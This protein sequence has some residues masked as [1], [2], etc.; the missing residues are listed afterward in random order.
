VNVDEAALQDGDDLEEQHGVVLRSAG[1]PDAAEV[2]DPL[3]RPAQVVEQP[4]NL[5]LGHLFVAGDEHCRR[6]HQ[7]RIGQHLD[8]RRVQGLH[9]VHSGQGRLEVLGEAL[10]TLLNAPVLMGPG[11]AE[12]RQSAADTA[13]AALGE[14]RFDELLSRGLAMHLADA[15]VFVNVMRIPCFGRRM[16]IGRASISWPGAS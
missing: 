10:W 11:Y 6:F 3:V 8:R 2:D 13:R 5:G 12:I 7:R 15:T 16:T 14:E 9:H 4:L 1:G